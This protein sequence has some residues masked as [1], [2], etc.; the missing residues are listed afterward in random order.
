MC[1][2][3]IRILA[4]AAMLAASGANADVIGGVS[5]PQGV[6]SFA[7]QVVSF[8]PGPNT[9]S[10]HNNP[11]AAIGAPNYATLGDNTDSLSTYV[12]LGWG[13]S[14]TLKF[15]DNSLTTS[16]TSALDLWVFEIGGAVEPTNVFISQDGLNWIDAGIV[17]G[18]TSGV[19]IDS[20]AG[21]TVGAQY[22]Y[23]RLIDRNVQ[24]SDAP[25]AGADIDAVGAISSAP[26]VV[27]NIPEP[28][29]IALIGL[30]LAGLGVMR[31]KQKVA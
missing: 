3:S 17:S 21:V 13:G 26:P 30:G 10:P 31:R 9:V 6:S 11:A 4:V 2:G 5:F 16:G 15:T 1:H 24:Y 18:A 25:W 28:A 12:A 23:V 7:D 19:D 22:S 27:G 8:T 20:L 29:S 14:L